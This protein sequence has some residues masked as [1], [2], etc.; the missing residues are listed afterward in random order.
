M[1]KL[2]LLT[3][4]FA[5]VGTACVKSTI[6][7]KMKIAIPQ[8][9]TRDQFYG[10]LKMQSPQAVIT[11]QKFI[12]YKKQMFL[13]DV[14]HGIH[15]IDVSNTATPTKIGFIPV[16]NANDFAIQDD[17]LYL[18]CNNDLVSLNISNLQE[19]KLEK[20]IVNAFNTSNNPLSTNNTLIFTH[21][22]MVDTVI[23]KDASLEYYNYYWGGFANKDFMTLSSFSGAGG[24]TG[25]TSVGGSMA[26]FTITK[27]HLYCVDNSRLLA[28]NI[29]TPKDPILAST[30]QTNNRLETIYPLSNNLFL[31]STTGMLIYN[32]N[33][34]STPTPVGSFNHA[35]VCDPVIADGNFAYVTLRSGTQCEGFTNQLDV[36]NISNLSTPSL[37]KSYTLT[38]PH[39]LS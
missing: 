37:V 12:L 33:N 27:Q 34:P 10:S 16:G 26:R 20:L 6:T 7:K 1:K 13:L 19:L 11:P 36:V 8:F 39:G 9:A 23:K 31:G 29:T 14:L 3:A 35:R 28:F 5:L 38:N 2:L 30:Q 17:I 24:S 32:I 25:G 15:I 18:D 22:R 4:L 21:Y